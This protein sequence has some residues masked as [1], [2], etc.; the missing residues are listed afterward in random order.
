MTVT[1][2]LIYV[3]ITVPSCIGIGWWLG[4]KHRRWQERR[5]P[6]QLGELVKR[7]DLDP[8]SFGFEAYLKNNPE[9]PQ[10]DGPPFN[11]WTGGG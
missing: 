2:Y 9:R 1:E 5:R 7:G 4:N 3:V 8:S 10:R 6:Q 11:F